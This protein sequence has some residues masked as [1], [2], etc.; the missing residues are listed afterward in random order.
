VQRP[1]GGPLSTEPPATPAAGT[2]RP[3]AAARRGC[4]TAAWRPDY[5]KTTGPKT[6]GLTATESPT[7]RLEAAQP[8]ARQQAK[9]QTSPALRKPRTGMRAAAAAARC[10]L[11]P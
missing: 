8:E 5:R 2:A 6:T 1:L 11:R 3:V 9:R 7:T 4:W 10:G